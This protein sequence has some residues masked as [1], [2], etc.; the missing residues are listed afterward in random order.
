MKVI[1]MTAE[2]V[3]SL[4]RRVASETLAVFKEEISFDGNNQPGEAAGEFVDKKGAAKILGCS[5]SSI[6][7]FARSGK[8]KKHLV[9][10]KAV[11]FL[12]SEVLGLISRKAK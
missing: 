9:G 8:L 6:E 12:R 10:A 4:V 2:E 11:R 5:V 3:E 7:V 1:L